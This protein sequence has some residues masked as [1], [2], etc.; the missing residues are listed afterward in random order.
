MEPL[1]GQIMMFAGNFA[2]RD[3]AFCD[4][5]LLPIAQYNALFSILGTTYGGDGRTTFALPDL[6]GRTPV[7]PGQGPGLASVLAGEK[8]GSAEVTLTVSNMPNHP[9]SLNAS[10]TAGTSSSP[11]GNYPAVSQ[12]QADRSSP[13]VQVNS[14]SNA[15]NETMAAPAVGNAGG[16][17][18][19]NNRNPYLGVYYIIALQGIYPSRP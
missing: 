9:H 6:R 7:H 17:I 1:I 3:W 18:P 14:Y 8:A 5:Q 11:V 12:F 16:S 2:P 13:V 4:G 19:F 10:N 15:S